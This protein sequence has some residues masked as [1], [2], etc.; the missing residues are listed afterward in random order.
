MVLGVPVTCSLFPWHVF[1]E[2][3]ENC[4]LEYQGDFYLF[5][6]L[7][8]NALERRCCEFGQFDFTDVSAQP[9]V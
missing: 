4:I 9:F 8:F 6:K 5:F 7:L 1:Q 2:R 3:K